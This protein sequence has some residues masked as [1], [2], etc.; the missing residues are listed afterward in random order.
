[1][2]IDGY[3]AQTPY[4]PH[5]PRAFTPSWIEHALRVQGYMPPRVP[6]GPFRYLD[7]GCGNGLHLMV[8]AAGCPE[9]MFVGTDANAGAID[10]A[11]ALAQGL[12]VTNVAYR[13]ETF[14][15]SLG[16]LSVVSR[17]WWK[18]AGGVIS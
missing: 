11:Q 16:R 13:A 10:R 8:M 18:F 7:L 4:P 5:F 14:A 6:R 2:E 9:G 12:G 3:F 17:K 1:M 15:E